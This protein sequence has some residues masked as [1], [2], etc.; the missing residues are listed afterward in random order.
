[1][2]Y[3]VYEDGPTNRVRVHMAT[4]NR[5]NDGQGVRGSRLPDNR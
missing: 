2:T 5:C 4:C 1:M 3:W